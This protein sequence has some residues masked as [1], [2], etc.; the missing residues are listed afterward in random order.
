MDEAK[1]HQEKSPASS[2]PYSAATET[3]TLTFRGMPPFG[4]AV[5]ARLRRTNASPAETMITLLQALAG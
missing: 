3:L 1:E 5:T 2:T 4:P